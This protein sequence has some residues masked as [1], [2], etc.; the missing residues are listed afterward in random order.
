MSKKELA[1]L[2]PEIVA[3]TRSRLEFN[4]GNHEGDWPSYKKQVLRHGT[5]I[6]Q[7]VMKRMSGDI[8]VGSLEHQERFA[9]ALQ[10]RVADVSSMLFECVMT[11]SKTTGRSNQEKAIEPD[12]TARIQAGKVLLDLASKSAVFRDRDEPL[13]EEQEKLT[14]EE[15]LSQIRAAEKIKMNRNET[16][17]TLESGAGIPSEEPAQVTLGPAIQRASGE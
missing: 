10:K 8:L 5:A 3:V 15:L 9:R 11:A 17:I 4:F 13:F 1:T 7:A 12:W 6:E 14:T 2:D 16:T